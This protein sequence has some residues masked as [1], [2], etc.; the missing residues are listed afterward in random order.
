MVITAG[1]EPP[2]TYAMGFPNA[3]CVP[4]CKATSPN[5]WALV[6][7]EYP[8]QFDRMAKLS[9]R[10]GTRL[11]RKGDERIFIDEVPLDQKTTEAIAPECDFLC[12]MAE[13]DMGHN[14]ELSRAPSALNETAGGKASA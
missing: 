10:L 6:R 5:Y 13:M 2:R 12:Q 3:N 14:A 4:C 7:K 11:T 8:I 9:R 1:I